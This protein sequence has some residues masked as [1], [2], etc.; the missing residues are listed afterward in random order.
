MELIDT[1]TKFGISAGL[2]N[3]DVHIAYVHRISLVA[4]NL[5]ATRSHCRRF[6]TMSS[7]SSCN[8]YNIFQN[9]V[10]VSMRIRVRN[11]NNLGS[12]EFRDLRKVR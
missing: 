3:Y 7:T 8:R 12:S 5:T 10:T 9:N 6:D 11:K 2:G 1:S 4:L